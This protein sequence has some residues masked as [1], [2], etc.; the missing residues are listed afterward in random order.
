MYFQ[1]ETDVK[2]YKKIKYY[3]TYKEYYIMFEFKYR[4]RNKLNKVPILKLFNLKA[5]YLKSIPV[6]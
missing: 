2:F 3:I 6:C 1:V 4:L 5:S